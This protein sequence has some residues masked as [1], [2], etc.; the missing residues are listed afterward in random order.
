VRQ[1]ATARALDPYLVLALIREESAFAP[2]ALS[3]TGARGLMQL[4]PQTADLTAREH[5]LPLVPPLILEVP[6]VNI[7]I[8]VN[9]LA[10]LM[11]DFGGNLSLAVA[12][13][14]AGKQAV[15]R[16]MQRYGFTD[17]VEFT[18][19]IPFT[20]TRMYVKRVLG[21]YDRYQT[22][23]GAPRAEKRDPESRPVRS[24]S[25][26]KRTIVEGAKK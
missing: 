18:E 6:E 19:D 5:K 9:H 22:L 17:E 8:G 14:N 4:M 20:E 13:Y 3:R 15:Q 1:H 26:K 10:D 12:A 23:Y 7:Q 24:D 2:H 16:W 25:S 11:G 21:S